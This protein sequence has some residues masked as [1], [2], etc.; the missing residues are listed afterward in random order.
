MSFTHNWFPSHQIV[1]QFCIEHGSDTVVLCVKSHN[2]LA[3][4][5]DVMYRWDLARFEFEDEFRGDIRYCNNPK[6]GTVGESLADINILLPEHDC[7]YCANGIFKWVF[8]EQK[9]CVLAK[10]HWFDKIPLG[11]KSTFFFG[12]DQ[13]FAYDQNHANI[14]MNFSRMPCMWFDEQCMHTTC[15]FVH[16]LIAVRWDFGRVI[17]SYIFTKS[18]GCIYVRSVTNMTVTNPIILIF[19]PRRVPCHWIQETFAMPPN[20]TPAKLTRRR[21]SASWSMMKWSLLY[22][23]S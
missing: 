17:L 23:T 10:S 8:L 13:C 15:N 11:V 22:V 1:L 5:I 4:E 2:D 16:C 3:T 20:A 19:P 21:T 7:G 14:F 9:C 6:E 12:R 18:T